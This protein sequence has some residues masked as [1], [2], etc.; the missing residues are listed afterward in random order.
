MV[1]DLGFRDHNL[2][3]TVQGFGFETYGSRPRVSTLLF[4]SKGSGS[5]V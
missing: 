1:S 4:S 5:K 3:F 2:S